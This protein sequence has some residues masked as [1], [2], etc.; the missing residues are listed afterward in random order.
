MCHRLNSGH[1]PHQRYDRYS[2]FRVPLD[3][4]YVLQN[5]STTCYADRFGGF[6]VL[7]ILRRRFNIINSYSFGQWSFYLIIADAFAA[8]KVA[9]QAGLQRKPCLGFHHICTA[10]EGAYFGAS[11]YTYDLL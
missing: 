1:P 8:Q 5:H 6:I 9:G 10:R 7:G 2:P 11:D 3:E 4:H